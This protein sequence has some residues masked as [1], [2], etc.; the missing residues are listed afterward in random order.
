MRKRPGEREGRTG[1]EG[2][3]KGERGNKGEGGAKGKTGRRCGEKRKERGR[4]KRKIEGL[5]YKVDVIT[6]KWQEKL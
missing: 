2:G 4:D 5:A 1:Y 6:W 3:K